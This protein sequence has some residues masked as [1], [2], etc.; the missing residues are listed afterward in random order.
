VAQGFGEVLKY[1]D[2]LVDGAYDEN[3]PENNGLP[4]GSTNQ[5]IIR[6]KHNGIIDKERTVWG[7]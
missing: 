5:S 2:V 3:K 6:F 1:V 7:N 4:R